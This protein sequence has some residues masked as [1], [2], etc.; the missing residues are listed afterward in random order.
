MKRVG[1]VLLNYGQKDLTLQ[2]LQAISEFTA[3][4][5]DVTVMD[6]SQPGKELNE[7]DVTKF[8]SSFHFWRLN[9]NRGFAAGNNPAIQK[10][11]QQDIEFIWLLNNDTIPEKHALHHILEYMDTHPEIGVAG[12]K[13]IV[14][15]NRNVVYGGGFVN[16]RKIYTKENPK[17]SSTCEWITGCSLFARREVF[18]KTGVLDDKFFMYFEDVDFSLRARNAGFG[19]GFSEK[20]EIIHFAG[21]SDIGKLS[22]AMA[23]ISAFHFAEKHSTSPWISYF[24]IIET[25]LIAPFLRGNFKKTCKLCLNILILLFRKIIGKK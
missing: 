23:F 2:C 21:S 25:R 20:A 12:M 22:H 7:N 18:E 13:I 1:I 19:I 8:G 11:L 10:Y 17:S 24:W 16:T 4:H 5:Y 14:P 9:E 15:S 6:N 3:N